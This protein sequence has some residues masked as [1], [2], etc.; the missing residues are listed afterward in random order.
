MA[1]KAIGE[2][3]QIK[4]GKGLSDTAEETL[5]FY[6]QIGVET[7]CM[8]PQLRME[9]TPRGLVPPAQSGPLGP[10][11]E[12][13][14]EDTLRT[15]AERI[16]FFGLVPSA[17]PLPV[18]G[19][20]VMG[21]EGRKEDIARIQECIRVAARVGI[22]VLTYNFT[23]LRASAGYA[24]REG[25]GRGG[26]SL[27]DFSYDRIRALPPL[28]DVGQHSMAEMWD[29]LAFFLHAVVPVAEN[30]GV[31]L[32]VHPNDPP[33]PTYRGVAQPLSD[34]NGLQHLIQLVDSPSNS[35]FF[36][37]GVLTEMGEDAAQA[38]RYFGSRDR[39]AIVHFRNVHVQVPRERY[40]E[41]FIEQGDC[42]MLACMKA[43]HDVGYKG[44]VDPDHTPAIQEDTPDTRIGWA[45]A[46]GHMIALRDAAERINAEHTL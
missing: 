14:K 11:P 46:I 19:N 23:A 18:S 2:G 22:R 12:A 29:R 34:L 36:D 16:R 45:F 26:S 20:I 4:I 32:A 5:R 43:L 35:L 30:V 39:I 28:Q 15:V 13:W 33:V 6:R 41:T 9:V 44:M 40:V 25:Q 24:T 27:R 37:T 3:H 31:R 21:R 1:D 38:I 42:D 17:M 8:P 10:Q 7:V